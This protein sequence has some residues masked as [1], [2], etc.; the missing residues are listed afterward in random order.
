[1][2]YDE[3]LNRC[4]KKI[5]SNVDTREGSF[6]YTALAPLCFELSQAYF[7]FSNMLDLTFLDTAYGEY[8]DK[9]LAVVGIARNTAV[10]CQKI[11]KIETNTDIIGQKFSC[12]HYIFEVLQKNADN[13]YIIEATDF[14]IE[15]NSI[16]GDL[17]SIMNLTGV[18]SAVIVENYILANEIEDDESLRSRAT[19][20]ILSKPFGGNVPDY[21]EKSLEIAGVSDVFVYNAND[22][23]IGN[24]HLVVLGSEKTPLSE[25]IC[26]NCLDFFNGNDILEGIAPIGHTVSVSTCED[27]LTDISC[28]IVVKSGE[29]EQLILENAKTQLENY[30]ADLDFKNPTVS[31]LKMISYLLQLDEITDV[32]KFLINGSEDNISLS[33]TYDKF[34]ICKINNISIE[35]SS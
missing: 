34:E 9:S 26:Q 21:E 22:L 12:E 6:I 7:E 23:G 25:Q 15:F 19:S 17:T 35:I 13:L 11:A 29:N 18:E 33:K 4:L 32:T 10:K 3:I 30:V 14:G 2:N 27:V 16:F 24:V 5:P 31:R 28:K 1:M 8:L 20:H